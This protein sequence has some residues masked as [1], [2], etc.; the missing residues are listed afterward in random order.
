[1]IIRRYENQR[2]R[3]ANVLKSNEYRI[4]N[5]PTSPQPVRC[6]NCP[7]WLYL[8]LLKGAL[9]QVVNSGRSGRL[10]ILFSDNLPNYLTP[11]PNTQATTI[12]IYIATILTFD[13]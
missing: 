7:R 1:M 3:I 2:I 12:S 11:K 8:L 9:M 5:S 4:R 6:L 10:F 13:S